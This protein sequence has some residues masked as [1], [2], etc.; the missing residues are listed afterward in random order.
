MVDYQT[1]S[2]VLT[3]IGIIVAITYYTL[4][5]RNSNRTRRAQLFMQIMGQFNTPGMAE[6]RRYYFDLEMSSLD[7][8][9]KMLADP[10]AGRV[11]MLFGGYLEGIGVLVRRKLIDVE[12]VVDFIG[13]VTKH[14]WEK[15]SPVFMEYRERM[16]APRLY[17]EWEYLY[18]EL[19]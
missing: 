4:T 17:S 1:I 13:G 11:F 15:F 3:G 12:M 6:S 9:M 19:V 2:I 7:D 18:N 14:F 8:Y 10:E 5:L 16:N